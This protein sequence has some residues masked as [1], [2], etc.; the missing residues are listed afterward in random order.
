M[1]QRA[2]TIIIIME[3]ISDD[4]INGACCALCGIYFKEEHGYPV[5]CADCWHT[6]C[7]HHKATKE[8]L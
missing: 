7:G 5:A 8:E 4:I 1:A 2:I 6:G 3:D